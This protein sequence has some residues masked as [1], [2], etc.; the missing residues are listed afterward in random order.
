M[1]AVTLTDRYV[2]AV[3]RTV[4]ERQRADVAAELR[5]AI[6][7]QLDARI[8]AGEDAATAEREVLTGLGD[9]DELAAGYADRPLHLLGPRLYLDWWRL[10]KLLLWIVVPLAAFG[11]SLG[12]TLSGAGIG[13]IIGSAVGGAITAGVHIVF[14]TTLVFV[15][16]ERSGAAAEMPR[17]TWTPEE[18]PEVRDTGARFSDML[19]SLIFFVVAAAVLVWDQLVGLVYLQGSWMPFFSPQLWPWWIGA[20]LAVMAVDAALNIVV[21][22]Q[23]RWT[24]AAAAVNAV[25][26]LL[27][28]VPAVWLLSQSMLLN[29]EFWL[30][31]IPDEGEK[32]FGILSIITGFG[33]AGVAIWDAVDAFLKARRSRR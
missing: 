23:R 29:P 2:D 5:A 10:V 31:V 21:Y 27:I 1:D 8:E 18:L 20:L 24:M 25:L 33:I 22:L 16:I 15:V 9:P 30:T 32:V 13:E 14:W 19:A 7:D 3:I 17:T 28:L 12:Q 6:A 11:I 4:P 26:N